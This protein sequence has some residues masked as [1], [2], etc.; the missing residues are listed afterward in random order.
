MTTFFVF[1][2]M[3]VIV[4]KVATLNVNCLQ[5]KNKQ[6]MLRTFLFLNSVDIML[7]QEVN[8]DNLDFLDTQYAYIT[9]PGDAQRGTAII[10]RSS[11][12]IE[13]YDTH[14]SGRAISVLFTNGTLVVNL[15]LPSGTNKRTERENFIITELPFFLRYHYKT[16][17]LGGDFNCVLHPTDQTGVYQT[18]PALNQLVEELNLKDAWKLLHP[19][20]V[21]FTFFRG[22]SASRLDR[23][24]VDKDT[25]NAIYDA[26]VM[27]IAFSDHECFTMTLRIKE[28]LATT[29]RS[30]WKLNP[31]LYSKEDDQNDFSTYL[32]DL[33]NKKRPLQANSPF[34]YWINTVKP[35][36]QSYFKRVG[37]IKS[38]EQ[39]ATLSFYYE[40]I[41]ELHGEIQK[42]EKVYEEMNKIKQKIFQF[43]EHIMQGV[44]IRC[45]PKSKMDN[46]K[47]TLFHVVKEKK[48]GYQK[49]IHHLRTND[50]QQIST[51]SD[52]LH[53]AT[54]HF[55][56]LFNEYP[57][58]SEMCNSLLQNVN[59]HISLED[60]QLLQQ[61][62]DEEEL[63]QALLGT[64]T[65]TSPGNDGITYDFY[66]TFWDI[67]K[68]PSWQP[69]MP[70]SLHKKSFITLEK[71]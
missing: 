23:I 21:Q 57:I 46:E 47:G 11:L 29:G 55:Q 71:A 33:I 30:Y 40:V 58:S 4:N 2:T 41:N 36:I 43:H 42:G 10:Y 53:E 69:S 44:M 56:E 66:K 7:L 34:K 13:Q 31:S 25:S 15:Y 28:K 8:V 59:R 17:I 70:F 45:R 12:E 22:E 49:Y 38:R 18:A 64:R 39:R 14:S 26:T 65:N 35:A 1:I 32:S 68:I 60:Q 20:T 54:R 63:R 51:T 62:I 37:S 61:P 48:R 67:L 9:N 5:N 50:N 52:C 16:L 27:P 24:Y 3:V 19:T 6:N